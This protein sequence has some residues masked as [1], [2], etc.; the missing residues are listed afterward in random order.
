MRGDAKAA[1]AGSSTRASVLVLLVVVVAGLGACGADTEPATGFALPEG[2]ASQAGPGADTVLVM[3]DESAIPGD[4]YFDLETVLSLPSR[5]FTSYDPWLD[6]ERSFTGVSLPSLFDAL[7]MGAAAHEVV[8]RASND[9]EVVVPLSMV[10]EYDY[11]LCYRENGRLY[12]ELPDA[13]NKGPLSIGIDFN[14][15]GSVD[16]EVFKFHSVWWVDEIE[17]R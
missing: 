10:K 15:M 4:V 12:E 7:D 16:R 2:F 6:E 14:L 1:V 3:R 9:Y 5:T 17:L 8:I 11:I 13:E